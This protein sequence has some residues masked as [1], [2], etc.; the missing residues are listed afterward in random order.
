MVPQPVIVKMKVPVEFFAV[1]V[2]VVNYLLY[3]LSLG[4]NCLIQDGLEFG[5][6]YWVIDFLGNFSSLFQVYDQFPSLGIYNFFFDIEFVLK[7]IGLVDVVLTR[8]LY[9]ILFTP[10]IRC[11]QMGLNTH[12][13][14]L[15]NVYALLFQI[16]VSLNTCSF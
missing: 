1:K 13:L 16:L 15:V 7:E 6:D 9:L 8:E 3:V 2:V 5:L 14:F 4:L 10:G 12:V 11:E